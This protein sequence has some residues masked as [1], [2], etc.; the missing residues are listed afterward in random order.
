MKKTVLALGLLL[1]GSLLVF[2]ACEKDDDGGDPIVTGVVKDTVNATSYSSWKYYSFSK[3]DTVQISNPET[4]TEWDIAFQ[5]FFIKTNGGKSGSG[6]AGAFNTLLTGVENFNTLT[7]VPDSAVFL[8]DDTVAIENYNP[9][10]P[11]EPIIVKMILSPVLTDW[12]TMQHGASTL[13][14]TKELLYILKTAD[15][16]YVKFMIT[17]YY[18]NEATSAYPSFQY[19]YQGD[20]SK[21]FK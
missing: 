16:K 12:Y 20:G 1:M 7:I 18:N 8:A 6:Q 5:R 21:N 13:L 2:N 4:S 11:S 17:N 3:G 14:I 19:V 10:N 9:A 15:G